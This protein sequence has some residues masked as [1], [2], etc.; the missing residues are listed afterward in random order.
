[1]KIKIADMLGAA[2][3]LKSVAKIELPV[4]A[5]YRLMRLGNKFMSEMKVFE[6]KRM[7]LL[8]KHGEELKK[9]FIQVKEENQEAFSKDI[10][11]LLDEEVN[12]DFDLIPIELFGDVKVSASD[13][14]G[15]SMFIE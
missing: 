11:S 5:S 6:T 1:M 8:K 9:G 10:Q 13:L 14:G 3:A 12:L 4:K 7:E 15:L 2:E